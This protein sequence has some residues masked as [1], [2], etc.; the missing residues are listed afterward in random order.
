VTATHEADADHTDADRFRCAL[1]R[2]PSTPSISCM[3]T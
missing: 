2:R 1:Q 3:R